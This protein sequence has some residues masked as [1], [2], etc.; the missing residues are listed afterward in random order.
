MS[1]L[2]DEI[3][4]KIENYKLFSILNMTKEHS[5]V[6]WSTVQHDFLYQHQ[7]ILVN[8]NHCEKFQKISLCRFRENRFNFQRP[9]NLS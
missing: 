1:Y 8:Q 2:Q 5:Q 3:T 4:H 9:L 6:A 7:K